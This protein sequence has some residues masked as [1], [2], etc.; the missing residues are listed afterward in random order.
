MGWVRTTDRGR[1]RIALAALALLHVSCGPRSQPTPGPQ[2]ASSRPVPSG[3][4]APAP[5]RVGRVIFSESLA[6]E[7][8]PDLLPTKKATFWTP[9]TEEVLALERQLP[10]FLLDQPEGSD[11]REHDLWL[12]APN[13]LRQYVGITRKG[14]RIVYANFF[15]NRSSSDR[16][17][18]VW[19]VVVKDGGSCYFQVEYDVESQR[20]SRL[21]VNGYA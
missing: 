11:A 6:R 4:P 1:R 7:R 21:S 3:P 5:K 8:L 19:P 18:H 10:D 16:D 9:S 20:F 12:K 15:C 17:W 2:A 13:Y 14:R